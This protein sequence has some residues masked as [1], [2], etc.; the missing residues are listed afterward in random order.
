MN[1]IFIEPSFPYNQREFVRGLHQAGAT[2]IGI[3][4]RPQEHLADD[5]RRTHRGL[6]HIADVRP[7]D[8]LI[9]GQAQEE[10]GSGR[11]RGG[12]G[13]ECATDTDDT[14]ADRERRDEGGDEAARTPD[15][16]H[17]G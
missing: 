11:H 3:G 5:L 8:H 15:G 17:A 7:H 12:A 6:S 9:I 13:Q 14:Q 16:I 2:V 1:I 10:Q 4:E